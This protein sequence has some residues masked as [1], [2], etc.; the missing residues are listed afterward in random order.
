MFSLV[1]RTN[2]PRSRSLLQ[3]GLRILSSSNRSRR[4]KSKT[5]TFHLEIDT[6]ER[7]TK[8][9]EQ[10]GLSVNVIANR[11]LR[12]YVEWDVVSERFRVASTFSSLLVKLMMWVPE[13]HVRELGKSQWLHEWR[14]V[15]TSYYREH[16]I[17][18]R[19]R[20]LELFGRYG[21]MFHFD[22]ATTGSTRMLTL[23]HGM[24]R[25][26]S[27]FYE[28]MLET[29]LSE[30]LEGK[31]VLETMLSE[32]LEG[33]VKRFSLTSTDNQVVAEIS[34]DP[35]KSLQPPADD[36]FKRLHIP[37]SGRERQRYRSSDLSPIAHET[38]GEGRRGSS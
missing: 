14:T 18:P 30:S 4:V 17:V 9:A 19:I 33:E 5:F 1:L 38:S 11:A 23:L 7:L 27:L 16:G 31:G 10:Q 34:M 24:G 15:A 32:S 29:M 26:W 28:G 25:K 6:I 2:T 3:R 37:M 8:E 20:V 21:R 13:E 36:I 35:L 22:Q 12:K